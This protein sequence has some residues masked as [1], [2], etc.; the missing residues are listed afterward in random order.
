MMHNL[1]L[2]HELVEMFLKCFAFCERQVILKVLLS[3]LF[4]KIIYVQRSHLE[5]NTKC[6]RPMIPN[7]LD[8]F[9]M[10]EN[11]PVKNAAFRIIPSNV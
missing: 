5:A 7:I 2:P 1:C 4:F 11:K 6:S 3:F 8:N 10:T 9:R